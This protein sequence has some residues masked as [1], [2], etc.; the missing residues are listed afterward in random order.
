MK[1]SEVRYRRLFQTAMVESRPAFGQVRG[2]DGSLD[3]QTS[4]AFGT[5]TTAVVGTSRAP[6]KPKDWRVVEILQTAFKKSEPSSDGARF[7][8]KQILELG[9]G[10]HA[11]V[12]GIGNQ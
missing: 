4:C 5:P 7:S 9:V 3:Q 2:L 12:I 11:G 8:G 6:L 1:D 10:M